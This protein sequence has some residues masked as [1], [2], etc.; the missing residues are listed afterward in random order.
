MQKAYKKEAIIYF[1]VL[2]L[3]FKK[4]RNDSNFIAGRFKA[5]FTVCFFTLKL[6]MSN[7][8]TPFFK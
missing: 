2:F 4:T 3:D 8:L 6:E 1:Y 7:Y 5:L